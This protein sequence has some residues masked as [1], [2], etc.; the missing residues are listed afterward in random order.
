MKETNMKSTPLTRITMTAVFAAL[1][2]SAQTIAQ[3]RQEQ[4]P[5]HFARYRVTDLGTLGGMSSIAFAV[6]DK[7]QVGGGANVPGEYQH[8]FL[9]TRRA[10][11]QDLGTLGGLNGNA[12]GPNDRGELAGP[13][14]TSDLDPNGEDF[15]GFGTH[16][17]CLG[18]VWK[19]GVMTPLPTLGGNNAEGLAINNRGQSVGAAENGTYD[20][21][22]EAPFQVFDFEAAIWE[23]NGKIRELPPLPGDTVGFALW[24]NNKGQ[25]VGSSGTCANTIPSGLAIGPHAVLWENGSPINLGSLG[26]TIGNTAAGINDRGEVVGGSDLADEK[27]GFPGRQVH[28][29]LWTKDTGMRDLGTVGS[30]FSSLPTLINNHG[31]IVGA[32]CDIDGNCRAFLWQNKKMK[33]LNTLIPPDSPLYLLFAFDINDAGDIVGQALETSTGELHA[34]LAT[35][36]DADA[37]DDSSERPMNVLPENTRKLFHHQLQDRYHNRASR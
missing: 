32:S 25:A 27:S 11:M 6:N 2:I 13:S 20:S 19:K 12:G 31:Q 26:G 16:L 23:P 10:G 9:W 36:D 28:G 3:D 17:S 33:D 29:F 7:G 14:E 18:F 22:C 37:A 30:D 35:P 24:I 4:K 1:A 5:K 34:F 15:C 8:P 21:S